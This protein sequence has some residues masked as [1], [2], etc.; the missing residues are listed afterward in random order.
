VNIEQELFS[1]IAT[2]FKKPLE[3]ITAKTLFLKEL[4]ADSLKMLELVSDIESKYNIKIDNNHLYDLKSV[5]QF[6]SLIKAYLAKK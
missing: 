4:E 5:G 1:I 2:S 6:I 3:K